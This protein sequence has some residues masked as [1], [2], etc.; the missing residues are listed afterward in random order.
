M[1]RL[2]LPLVGPAVSVLETARALATRHQSV[3]IL[4]HGDPGVGKSH[5]L[6]LLALEMTGSPFAIERVNGQSLGIDLVREWRD[7]AGCGNLFSARTVKRIDELDESSSSARAEL[8]T[9]LDYLPA[10]MMVLATTNNYGRLRAESKGRLETRFKTLRVDA[11]SIQD[12]RHYLRKQFRVPVGAAL[13]IAQGAVPDGCL[14]SEGVNMRACV[15]DA[16][17]F[18]AASLT[19]RRHERGAESEAA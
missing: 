15:E 11:P 4:L 12:A 10:G 7:R 14:A 8:L 17:A 16:E 13:A 2:D 19:L 3:A 1:I 9:Y 18:A 6:D 5:L